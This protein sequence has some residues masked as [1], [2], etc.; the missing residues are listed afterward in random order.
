MKIIYTNLQENDSGITRSVRQ[1]RVE[2]FNRAGRN[3]ACLADDEDIDQYLSSQ[4]NSSSGKDS[5]PKLS[6]I[7]GNRATKAAADSGKPGPGTTPEE[8]KQIQQQ[9]VS[10]PKGLST[11]RSLFIR[12]F[13]ET[14]ERTAYSAQYHH[15]VDIFA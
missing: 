13:V 10:V 6:L 14:Q 1:V 12:K 4:A 15:T 8:S 7:A 9:L 11:L 5:R 2:M 3:Q